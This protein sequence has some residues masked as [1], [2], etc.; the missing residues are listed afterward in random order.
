MGLIEHDWVHTQ[1]TMKPSQFMYEEFIKK[2]KDLVK[3]F[4]TENCNIIIA[5]T[6]MRNNHDKDL[7]AAIPEIDFVLGG[8]DHCF[9]Y[10][11]GQAG[12]GIKSGTDFRELTVNHVKI[13][14]S[15]NV[16]N[17]ADIIYK[18]TSVKKSETLFVTILEK[19]NYALA[20]ETELIR[21]VETMNEDETIRK[22]VQ[23]LEEKTKE[24][25]KQVIGHLSSPVDARFTEIRNRCLP[26]GNFIADIVKIF[27]H[28][29]CVLKNSGALRIDSVINQGELT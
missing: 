23:S 3:F 15:H 22:Y 12:I 8:H 27:M 1:P 20:V 13:Y 29:D 26:L 24:K 4:K 16:I 2:G 18:A 28:T 5:L 21:I 10:G 11:T 14:N 7:L 6:H 17:E 25:F 9:Y 19:G